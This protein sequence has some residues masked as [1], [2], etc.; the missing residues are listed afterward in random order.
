MFDTDPRVGKSKKTEWVYHPEV[1]EPKR[2]VLAKQPGNSRKQKHHKPDWWPEDKKVEAATL[3]AATRNMKQVA[4]LSKVSLRKLNEWKKEPWWM[5]V[6][7]RCQKEKNDELDGMLTGVIH[8]AAEIISERLENGNIVYDF[9]RKEYVRIPVQ[10]RDLTIVQGILFDKRQLLRGEATSRTENLTS[11]QKLEELK[12]AFLQIQEGIT[13]EGEVLD[14]TNDHLANSSIPVEQLAVN[15]T[16]EGS[17]PSLPA[18]H[19]GLAEELTSLPNFESGF[20]THTPLQAVGSPDELTREHLAGPSWSPPCP[21]I[22]EDLDSS[23]IKNE[24]DS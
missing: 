18:I 2:I 23:P 4:A 15:E 8:R 13:I 12:Q 6:V 22:N 7:S 3:W 16:V 19:A 21:G 20:D 9:R 14:V 11:M 10:L 5:N 24:T 1:G 17:S